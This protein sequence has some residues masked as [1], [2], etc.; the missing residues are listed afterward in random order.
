MIGSLIRFGSLGWS[1]ARIAAPGA[2]QRIVNTIVRARTTPVA[3]DAMAEQMNALANL[4]AAYQQIKGRVD[5]STAPHVVQA[6]QRL[7]EAMRSEQDARE[8]MIKE[9]LNVR[10]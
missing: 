8:A 5:A 7:G 4:A 2:S 9:K 6:R 3:D 10:N 1:I